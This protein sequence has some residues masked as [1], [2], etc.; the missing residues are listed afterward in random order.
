MHARSLELLQ[1]LDTTR[2]QLAD[3]FAKVPKERQDQ[4]PSSGGWSVG[5]VLAHLAMIEPS[6]AGILQG[7]LRRALSDGALPKAGDQPRAWRKLSEVLLDQDR[8]IEAPDFVVPD[9]TMT[10]VSAW[11]SLQVSRPKLRQV[12]LAADGI[13]TDSVKAQHVLLGVMTFEEWLGFVGFHEQRH[14]LQITAIMAT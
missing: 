11:D 7:K 13:C 10:A 9:G 1:H 4:R 12:L 5:E 14:A 3:A 2:Q 6:V 8:K